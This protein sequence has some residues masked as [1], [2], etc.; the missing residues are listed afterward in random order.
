VEA[1]ASRIRAYEKA[2][3]TGKDVAEKKDAYKKQLAELKEKVE[4][5]NLRSAKAVLKKV[6][7]LNVANNSANI[8]EFHEALVAGNST[9]RNAA[10]VRLGAMQNTLKSARKT[11]RAAK[12]G[13][14]LQSLRNAGYNFNDKF[15]LGK[16]NH[17]MLGLLSS[18]KPTAKTTA[19]EHFAERLAERKEKLAV[20]AAKAAKADLALAASNIE[21][22]EAALKVARGGK[23]VDPKNV[24]RYARMLAL[25][26]GSG[27]NIK[28]EHYYGIFREA[29]KTRRAKKAASGAGA[30]GAAAAARSRSRS[31]SRSSSHKAAK[32][33]FNMNSE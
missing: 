27:L 3:E 10:L 5:A 16:E 25:S 23:K 26:A 32:F 15:A 33:G 12:V 29:F 20:K 11:V 2:K 28:P 8:K 22:A 17:V 4:K 21:A 30:A 24:E 7:K 13:A 1:V 6:H 19:M 18:T 14:E 31:S 9:R